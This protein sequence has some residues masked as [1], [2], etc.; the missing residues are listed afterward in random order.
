[1]ISICLRKV[2]YKSATDGQIQELL[3][4]EVTKYI[5]KLNTICPVNID[6]DINVVLGEH[7][8]ISSSS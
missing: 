4:M 5:E 1:M 8:W 6:L 3:C 7:F 2:I